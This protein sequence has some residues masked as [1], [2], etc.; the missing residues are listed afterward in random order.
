[1]ATNAVPTDPTV[2]APLPGAHVPAGME[3]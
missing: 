1:M 2:I 3:I